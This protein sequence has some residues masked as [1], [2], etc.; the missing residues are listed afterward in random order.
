MSGD[1]ATPEC[2]RRSG[3][4]TGTRAGG[5]AEWARAGQVGQA[6]RNERADGRMSG[7]RADNATR[8][9]ATQIT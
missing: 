1:V 6:E 8:E 3:G 4:R 7:R 9:T 5:R 2:G